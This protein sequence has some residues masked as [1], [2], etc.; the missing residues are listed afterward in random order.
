MT[1]NSL[2]WFTNYQGFD[3][4][5]FKYDQFK[6]LCDEA[7][8]IMRGEKIILIFIRAFRMNLRTWESFN[9][10][11]QHLNIISVI[12]SLKRLEKFSQYSNMTN[13]ECSE[14]QKLALPQQYFNVKPY[15]SETKLSK[16]KKIVKKLLQS[17]RTSKYEKKLS[18]PIFLPY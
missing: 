2:S 3:V 13:T 9:Q 17:L 8:V 18:F 7:W 15:N 11:K 4:K 10:G 1:P 12:S 16:R 14:T 5:R 6:T